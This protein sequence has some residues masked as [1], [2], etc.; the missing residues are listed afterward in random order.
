M[1]RHN[2]KVQISGPQRI[3]RKYPRKKY[4]RKLLKVR[5]YIGCQRPREMCVLKCFVY[6]RER[7]RGREKGEKEKS[8]R[9]SRRD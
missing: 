6:E 9:K 1:F 3:R 7:E 4:V 8:I 5:A 2:R